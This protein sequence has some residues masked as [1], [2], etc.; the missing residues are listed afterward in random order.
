VAE[1]RVRHDREAGS[2]QQVPHQRANLRGP[3]GHAEPRVRA[4]HH[5][6]QTGHLHGT[7][8]CLELRAGRLRVG[9]G[10]I[11]EQDL[12]SE[13]DP[14]VLDQ[15]G[16][17]RDLAAE[18]LPAPLAGAYPAPAA[19]VVPGP[20]PPLGIWRDPRDEFPGPCRDRAAGKRLA[21]HQRPLEEINCLRK[22]PTALAEMDH[23]NASQIGT[24]PGI[25]RQ[26]LMQE[27]RIAVPDERLRVCRDGAGVQQRDQFAAA[28]PGIGHQDRVNRLVL[29][30]I[31]DVAGA[32]S[33]G[34]RH[35]PVVVGNA[36]RVPAVADLEAEAGQ[37]PLGPGGPGGHAGQGR[38]PGADYPDVAALRQRPRYAHGRFLTPP[39]S[40]LPVGSRALFRF[41]VRLR[42]PV[43][44]A[45]PTTRRAGWR[46]GRSRTP[47]PGSSSR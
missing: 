8:K 35:C 40:A 24:H 4:D 18:Q 27:Y 6:G 19:G 30:R 26:E 13:L 34:S 21:A 41:P 16:Q 39:R 28:D 47:P 10:H 20:G 29:E 22:G 36:E 45:P 42:F 46:T 1:V 15:S 44:P 2:R 33:R 32:F 37:D 23:E 17:D 43:R 31:H 7:E 11:P 25:R 14:E 38:Q 12:P 5:A 9:E 3:F